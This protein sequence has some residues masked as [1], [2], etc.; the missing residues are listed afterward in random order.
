MRVQFPE[1]SLSRADLKNGAKTPFKINTGEHSWN[2]I[3]RIVKEKVT[4]VTRVDSR[5]RTTLDPVPDYKY[6]NG[7]KVNDIQLLYIT[8]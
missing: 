3:P 5:Y 6:K 8:I 1:I 4:I 7:F 2:R